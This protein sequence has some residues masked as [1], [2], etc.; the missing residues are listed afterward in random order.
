MAKS[1]CF[2]VKNVILSNFNDMWWMKSNIRAPV[3]FE[4]IKL[5]AK[6]R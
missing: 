3:F 4:F 1:L 6:K 5:V 2:H